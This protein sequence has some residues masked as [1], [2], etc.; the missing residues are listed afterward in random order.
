MEAIFF[1]AR[2]DALLVGY[3]KFT[4]VKTPW[5]LV[6]AEGQSTHNLGGMSLQI[7]CRLDPAGQLHG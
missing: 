6:Y 1:H 3:V 5:R 7:T 4:K 2:H